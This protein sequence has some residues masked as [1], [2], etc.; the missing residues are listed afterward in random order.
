MSTGRRFLLEDQAELSRARLE[1]ARGVQQV[2][3]SGLKMMGVEAAEE[4]R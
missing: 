4:L 3:R 1:L 2:I